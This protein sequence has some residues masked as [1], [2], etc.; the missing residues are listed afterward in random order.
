MVDSTCKNLHV[1]FLPYMAPGHMTPLV[2]IAR[3]FAA[4]SF[5]VTIIATPANAYCFNKAINR[6][7][8]SGRKI[9]IEILPFPSAQSGL[10]EG[11]ENL[12]N[13]HTPEMTIKLFNAIEM[14][15]PQIEKLIRKNR[16]DCIASDV[17]FHWTANVAADLGIPRLAFS[18]SGFFNLSV[19]Y[20][21]EHYQ[22]HKNIQSETEPFILPTLPHKVMLTRSQLPDVVK[23]RNKFSK[24][25]EQLKEAEKKSYGMLVNSFK[26]LDK[27]YAD[28]Y[29][30]VRGIKA[31]HVGPVSLF[32]KHEDDKVERGEKAL[33]SIDA[34]NKWMNSKSP[35]TVVY[36]CF[37]S[38]IRFSKLQIKEI[39]SA[40]ESTGYFFIW[41]VGKV[42]ESD[43]NGEEGQDGRW[44]PEGFE[45]RTKET[46]RGMI[47]RGW[48]PQVVILEHAAIGGF[49]THCG[50]NSIMEGVTAG[51]PMITWPVFAEQF[52]NEK[53]VTQVLKSG[54]SVGNEMWKAWATEDGALIRREKIEAAMRRAMDGRGE[55]VE[56][57]RK[58]AKQLGVLAKE[59]VEEGG[60]SYKDLR[61]LMDEIK[62]FERNRLQQSVG[63]E[64]TNLNF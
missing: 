28:Y 2:D 16:P 55:D 1:I 41:V 63:N 8:K 56:Q 40:L 43:K 50:W 24:L 3:L 29:R 47:I 42:L 53:L 33:I 15:Q 45:E 19:A 52:Y 12:T 49:L 21:V 11:C 39:A 48:G 27:D 26:E 59:A 38:L 64:N 5:T 25:F 36:V 7:I 61:N 23:T 34:C 31:W 13:A 30:T 57:M 20:C 35:N 18:G 62:W 10:P 51:V 37:G 60:S 46:G 22:P 54:V 58:T 4:H 32:N 9:S 17:L 14:L 6:D 44:L